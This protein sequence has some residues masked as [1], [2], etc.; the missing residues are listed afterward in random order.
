MLTVRAWPVLSISM[1]TCLSSFLFKLEDKAMDELKRFYSID[2][3]EDELIVIER[4]TGGVLATPVWVP[5]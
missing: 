3:V 1:A 5:K 2:S 4:V